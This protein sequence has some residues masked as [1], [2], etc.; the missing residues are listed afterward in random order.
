MIAE[1]MY[2]VLPVLAIGFIGGY[3]ARKVTNE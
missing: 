2:I 1:I 3:L